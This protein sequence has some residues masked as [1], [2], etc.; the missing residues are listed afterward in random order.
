MFKS[1]APLVKTDKGYIDIWVEESGEQLQVP[2]TVI[3]TAGYSLQSF[4]QVYGAE[5]LMIPA[6]VTP[7]PTETVRGGEILIPWTPE[8]E[9]QQVQEAIAQDWATELPRMTAEAAYPSPLKAN[10]AYA[11]WVDVYRY[12]HD[13]AYRQQVRA[14]GG[15]WNI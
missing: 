3:E 12:R 8:M 4:S 6:Y 13:F 11:D 2:N 15:T 7:L 14:A 1:D 5:P 10:V 9:A